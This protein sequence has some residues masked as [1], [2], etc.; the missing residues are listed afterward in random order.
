MLSQK[1]MLLIGKWHATSR[2]LIGVGDCGYS[3]AQQVWAIHGKKQKK[4][5]DHYDIALPWKYYE[6]KFPLSKPMAKRCNLI[7]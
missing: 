5:K 7:I 3:K 2:E 6:L 1:S 4:E